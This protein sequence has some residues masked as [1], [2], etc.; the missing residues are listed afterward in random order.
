M[1]FLSIFLPVVTS[2]V[3]GRR[4]SRRICDQQGRAYVGKYILY[5]NL[6]NAN[7]YEGSQCLEAPSSQAN[8]TSWSSN[9]NWK[10]YG[11]PEK[12]NQVKSFSNVYLQGLPKDISTIQS[13]PSTWSWSY[14]GNSVRADVAYDLFLGQ[15]S[16]SRPDVE[17]MIWVGALGGV[18]PISNGDKAVNLDLEGINWS[19]YHGITDFNGFTTQVYSFVANSGQLRDFKGDINQFITHLKNEGYFSSKYYLHTLDAGTEAF[20]GE[21]AIFDTSVY[22]VDLL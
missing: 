1:L 15:H 11:D 9:W 20:S 12:D 8:P 16:D 14:S 22:S 6:W 13:I 3:L 19:L 18:L 7:G 4:D 2:F 10:F 5:N 21:N 17:I